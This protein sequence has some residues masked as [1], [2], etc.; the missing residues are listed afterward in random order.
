ML[1]NEDIRIQKLDETFQ[2]TTK[3]IKRIT[4]ESAQIENEYIQREEYVRERNKYVL[5]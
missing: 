2:M 1:K 4:S 3:V 5:K